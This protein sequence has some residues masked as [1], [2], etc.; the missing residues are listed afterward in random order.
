MVIEAVEREGFQKEKSSDTKG[1]F[2]T[3]FLDIFHTFPFQRDQ[4][5]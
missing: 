2:E 1:I 3:T 4:R 5:D